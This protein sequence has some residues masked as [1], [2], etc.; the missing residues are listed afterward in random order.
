VEENAVLLAQ[1]LSPG[2]DK[3]ST[4]RSFSW[5]KFSSAGDSRMSPT[6]AL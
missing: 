6:P 2:A 3:V 1:R 5:S 4:P